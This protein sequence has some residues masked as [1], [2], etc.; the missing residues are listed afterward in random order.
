VALPP[1]CDSLDRKII[2]ALLRPGAAG[3]SFR[4]LD[5]ASA[6]ET[7]MFSIMRNATVPFGCV[8]DLSRFE[9]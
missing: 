2:A 4:A 1:Q 6:R 8:P 3:P 7:L 5:A 9:H